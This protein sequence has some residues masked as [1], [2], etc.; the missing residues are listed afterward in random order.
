LE[1]MPGNSIAEVGQSVRKEYAAE[2]VCQIVVPAHDCSLS[3]KV[4]LAEDRVAAD[5]W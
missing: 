2:E 5:P 4:V 3:L 1:G